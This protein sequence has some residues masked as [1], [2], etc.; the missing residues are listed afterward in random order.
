MQ[1]VGGPLV[2]AGTASHTK[3][4]TVHFRIARTFGVGLD[5]VFTFHHDRPFSVQE[6]PCSASFSDRSRLSCSWPS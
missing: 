2:V 3:I 6:I 1:V 4:R 5:E